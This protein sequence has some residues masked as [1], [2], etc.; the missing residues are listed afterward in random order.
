MFGEHIKQASIL[1]PPFGK[2]GIKSTVCGPESF[3]PDHK[4]IVGED[5]RLPGTYILQRFYK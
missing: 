5:P 1:C 3:T 2:A 4:P